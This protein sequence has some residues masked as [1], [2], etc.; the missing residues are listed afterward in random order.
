MGIFACDG[1]QIYLAYDADGEALTTAYDVDGETVFSQSHI[2]KVMEYNVGEWYIGNG[3]IVPAEKDT[4]YYNLQNGMIQAADPDIMLICENRQTFSEAGRTTLSMLSQYF[5]YIHQQGD[6][7]YMSRAV[8]SKYPISNYQT[9]SFSD[10]TS[11][12]YDSCTITIDGKAITVVVTHLNYN[13]GSQTTRLAQTSTLLSFLATLDTFICG[14]DWNL[15]DCKSTSGSD[16][17]DVIDPILQ[18]G[19]HSANCTDFGFLETYSN[20]PGGSWTG[21]L[22]DIVT[23]GDIQIAGASVDTTKLTD[24]INDTVDHMPLTASLYIGNIA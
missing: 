13:S 14:G 5:E 16:Y 20:Q 10:G 6:S 7:G 17:A 11:N 24:N 9:H 21:C 3:S 15:L 8:C 2:I 19:F 4:E 12:Y 1:Q 23:S 18:A 22:D